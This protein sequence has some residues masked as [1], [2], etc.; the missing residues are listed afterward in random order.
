[1][2]GRNPI[3]AKALAAMGRSP[4]ANAS[5]VFADRKAPAVRREAEEDWRWAPPWSVDEQGGGFVVR[6]LCHCLTVA[7][8]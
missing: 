2:G 4:I 5:Q 6:T 7:P 3:N 1:M 8:T